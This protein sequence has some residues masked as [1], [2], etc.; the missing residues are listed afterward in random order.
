MPKQYSLKGFLRNAD[1]KHIETY[2]S[3]NG[4]AHNLDFSKIKETKIEPIF[5]FISELSEEIRQKINNDFQDIYSLSY[6]GGIKI[7]LDVARLSGKELEPV[8][9][10]LNGFYDKSFSTFL[11]HKGI[12]QTSLIFSRIDNLSSRYWRK[13]INLPKFSINFDNLR[14]PLSDGLRDYFKSKEGRGHSCEIDYY[15]RDNFH[16]FY[17]EPEDYSRNE[18]EWVK[19]ERKKRSYS[20]AFE[21]VFVYNSKE[22]SLDTYFEGDAKSCKELQKIFAQVMLG[23]DKLPEENKPVYELKPFRSASTY[24][25]AY[26][27]DSGIKSLKVKKIKL[28]LLGSKDKIILEADVSNN[29]NAVYELMKEKLNPAI[30]PYAIVTQ[31]GIQ[32][33]MHANNRKGQRVRNFDITY[34]NSCSLKYDGDDLILRKMLLDSGIEVQNEK[35]PAAVV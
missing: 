6:E 26:Q 19:G 35:V 20:P 25:F 28:S 7:I 23:I 30:V 34:P 4:I 29:F 2:L 5:N 21:V 10:K 9:D 12:F 27:P 15:V 24:N 16:Y 14:S 17:A 3:E 1:N 32:A 8:F 11:E 22:G 18:I 31:V 33:I 13:I